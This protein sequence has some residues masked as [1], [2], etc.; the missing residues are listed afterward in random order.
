MGI[1]LSASYRGRAPD[2]CSTVYLP[3]ILLYLASLIATPVLARALDLDRAVTFN[4]PSQ[5]LESALIAFSQQAHIQVVIAQDTAGTAD[6]SAFRGTVP[7][8]VALETLL[9]NS[10]FKY[11]AVGESVSIT[12]VSEAKS[13]NP[14]STQT[15]IQTARVYVSE[16]QSSRSAEL[17]TND[18]SEE[19]APGSQ[20]NQGKA[21]GFQLVEVVVT[22]QKRTENLQDVP[23][24]VTAISADTL[25]SNNQLRIQDYYTSFPGLNVTPTASGSYQSLTIRGI[26]AGVVANP[27]VGVTVDD[28]PYGTSTSNGGG[29]T[30]QIVPDVDP[31]DLARVEVL[32]GP[33]GTLYGASSMGGLLKF[34][35]VDPS[36]DAVSGR[37]EADLSSVYN[38]VDLGYG[39]RGSVNFPLS[40]TLAVRAS[41]FTRLDPGYITN[42]ETGERDANQAQGDGGRL[43]AL[44][45]PSELFSLK[46]SAV[47]QKIRGDG[48]PDVDRPINGFVVPVALGD[49]EQYHIPGSGHYE[50]S[51]QA[52]SAT[53]TAKLG[54]AELTAISGYNVQ[55]FSDSYDDTQPY[56]GLAAKQLFGV[57]GSI[58]PENNKTKKFT[59]ELRLSVPIGQRFEW[60][61]GGFY[62]DE[63]STYY[64]DILAANPISGAAVGTT[65]TDAFAA[66]YMEAAVFT[67]LTIHLTDRFDIQMGG[68]ESQIRQTFSDA[69]TGPLVIQFYGMPSPVN[70]P[71]L[72]SKAN[73]FTYLV[74]PQLKLSSDLMTYARFASGYRPG[75]SNYFSGAGTPNEYHPDKTQ[76]Y[77]IGVKGEFLDR[78]FSVDASLY[79]IDWNDIQLSETNPVNSIGYIGNASRA[80]SQGLELSGESRPLTGLTISAWIT[81]SDAVLTQSF[82]PNS[83]AYGVSGDRLPY[84]SRFSGNISLEQD[85]PLASRVTGFVGGAVSYI[86][87]REGEFAGTATAER[88]SYPSYTNTDLRAGAKYD[89]WTTSLSINNV[90][91]QRGILSGGLGAFPRYGFI[92]IQ[93]R[94]VALAVVK[95]F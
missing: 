70:Q 21:R 79:Y 28:V 88:Q 23:V 69:F 4:I 19:G 26:S 10:G 36:T 1:P 64:Q 72:D 15:P 34:V 60:L 54:I 18:R 37:V 82:P 58:S 83:N 17:S 94:T 13:P 61:L 66:T 71:Q 42:V 55:A 25:V 40:D 74:T 12:H 30:G 77:E 73:A 81:L 49:L 59:Q 35:T 9:K 24:P 84:S 39:M 63:N 53:M 57:T 31:G 95:T 92:Y 85:F 27:T 22:A 68:R 86:G 80:K 90:A 87:N 91:D 20:N 6:V 89:S 8:R 48:T 32:R 5:P 46:L 44:W 38:G 76:N 45:R 62:T 52:L 75:G 65:L 33:Q 7:A 51:V 3:V 50:R 78:T 93:P 11:S 14:G 56:F 43:S 29:G 41:G 47:Y 67:N 2:A 16:P